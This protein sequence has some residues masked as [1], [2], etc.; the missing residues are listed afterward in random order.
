MANEDIRKEIIDAFKAVHQNQKNNSR[1]FLAGDY[2]S[3]M[4]FGEDPVTKTVHVCFD[5]FSRYDDALAFYKKLTGKDSFSPHY[6]TKF[7]YKD[8][9]FKIYCSYSRS[10]EEGDVVFSGENLE[11]TVHGSPG[12][13]DALNK[14][15]EKFQAKKM[16]YVKKKINDI[17]EKYDSYAVGAYAFSYVNSNIDCKKYPIRIRSRTT[18]NGVQVYKELEELN[19][20]Y[21]DFFS[22]DV[23]YDDDYYAHTKPQKKNVCYDVELLGFDGKKVFAIDNL[24][25]KTLAETE[26]ILKT[27]IANKE[28]FKFRRS[29]LMYEIDNM[30][31]KVS[32]E[33]AIMTDRTLCSIM[34]RYNCYIGGI[35]AVTLAKTNMFP[36]DATIKFIN[37]DYRKKFIEELSKYNID[38]YKH[39]S[40]EVDKKEDKKYEY[41][42]TCLKF[43]GY[44]YFTDDG[45]YSHHDIVNKIRNGKYS[46]YDKDNC[47]KTG[48]GCYDNLG[49]SY[50]QS[51]S[52]EKLFDMIY[53]YGGVVYACSIIDYITSGKINKNK[54]IN[55]Y[56]ENDAKARE[57]SNELEKFDS[58][59]SIVVKDTF[60][61]KLSDVSCL[62]FDGKN[63]TVN[64]ENVFSTPQELIEKIKRKEYSTFNG[65]KS[66]FYD[67]L[68]FKMVKMPTKY[69]KFI[70]TIKK[71]ATAAAYSSA[72]TQA[73]KLTQ[74]ALVKMA[75]SEEE[76]NNLQKFFASDIGF[77][78][79][80]LAAGTGLLYSDKIEDQRVATIAEKLRQNG[81]VKAGNFLSKEVFEAMA[82]ELKQVIENTPN[83]RVRVMD[84]NLENDLEIEQEEQASQFM[85]N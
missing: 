65:E 73:V 58:N 8:I 85:Q 36:S 14:A 39:V 26:E 45:K 59:F 51:L 83:V 61:S 5:K 34:T 80:S 53:K 1:G 47:P 69:S 82:P 57:F 54:T 4:A 18:E 10:A 71:D 24:E 16:E 76:A 70:S 67:G 55:I 56:F 7:K 6:D 66:S 28:A 29:T 77:S 21:G 81:M 3:S 68:G 60:D 48:T 25:G 72:A 43:N 19:K 32:E 17:L 27:K 84:E 2:I 49:L 30:Q 23:S 31:L 15:K 22:Y 38:N 20:K 52:Q 79:L 46:S 9:T 78:L 35:D 11:Y 62:K 41:D 64:D 33:K 44:S 37:E 40:F 42:I 75:K 13:K 50:F 74:A 12:S 63:F